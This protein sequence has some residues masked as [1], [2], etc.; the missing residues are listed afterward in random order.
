[1]ESTDTDG[2]GVGH[3]NFE[4][5]VNQVGYVLVLCTDVYVFLGYR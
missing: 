4:A 5:K 3:V 2:E 1:M